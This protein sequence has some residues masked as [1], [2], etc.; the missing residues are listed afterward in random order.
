MVRRNFFLPI[1]LVAAVCSSTQ[2]ETFP[3]RVNV[4]FHT[5]AN[6]LVGPMV[7]D[8]PVGASRHVADQAVA[9]AFRR[10]KPDAAA[11]RAAYDFLVRH[12]MLRPGS[13]L[14]FTRPV[15]LRE[16]GRLRLPDLERLSR[17][18]GR[19]GG[20]EITFAYAGWTAED[21]ARVDQFVQLMYPI[22]KQ[23][24]GEPSATITLRIVRDDTLTDASMHLRNGVYNVTTNEVRFNPTGDF[25]D[26]MYTLTHLIL[27]AFHDD[28]MFAYDAWEEGFTWAATYV[29]FKRVYGD[30]DL[31]ESFKTF[32][33]LQM[34]EL[35]NL[36]GV[37]NPRFWP[38]SFDTLVAADRSAV[39]P[40]TLFVFRSAMAG[41]AW[42]KCYIENNN[43]F[44]DF[45]A[46]YY[47]RFT[48]QLA[49]HIPTLKA[50]AAQI[51]PTVEGLPFEDWYRRQYILDTSVSPGRHLWVWSLPQFN[52]DDNAGAYLV[53]FLY[54]FNRDANGNELPLA[55]TADL[56]YWSWDYIQDYF[57]EEGNQTTIP[58]SG[59]TAGV[60]AIS[61]GIFNVGGS[62]KINVQA[63]VNGLTRTVV[64]PYLVRGTEADPNDFFG[65]TLE[66]ETGEVGVVVGSGQEQVSAIS[67]SAFGM[68]AGM[69][70]WNKTSIRVTDAATARSAIRRNGL[71]PGCKKPLLCTGVGCRW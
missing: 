7:V 14:S 8:V 50:I 48:G 37:G 66:T 39:F 19:L 47:Q 58:G 4:P 61:P 23:V 65:A 32:Y 18:R 45:N 41:A 36:P 29:I 5:T 21:Q 26:D 15:V 70:G 53:L 38:G 24:Y 35:L 17:T 54:H 27:Y 40:F 52:R 9:G 22:A 31:G 33:F 11:A 59:N 51:V 46:A 28:A 2:A 62:Q 25:R 20:G 71:D 44:R 67:Q 16:G 12:R 6:G 1:L 57:A 3:N 69:N 60:G 64:W 13:S 68:K 10:G 49:G 30:Y 55:G 63:S 42:V 56:V 34:Y 43:F